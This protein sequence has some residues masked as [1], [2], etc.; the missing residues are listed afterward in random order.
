MLEAVVNTV[1]LE[2]CEDSEYTLVLET[3]FRG[4]GLSSV[5]YVLFLAENQALKRLV[6]RVEEE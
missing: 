2:I 5:G 3:Q 1:L 4:E 6:Q